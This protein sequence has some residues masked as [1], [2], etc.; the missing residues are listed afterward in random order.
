MNQKDGYD[1]LNPLRGGC[2]NSSIY[3]TILQELFHSISASI[4]F[5]SAILRKFSLSTYI[6]FIFILS[7]LKFDMECVF[8]ITSYYFYFI[9]WVN[10]LIVVWFDPASDADLLLIQGS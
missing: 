9:L 7:R 8:E 1:N 6:F 5:D 4:Y 10:S 3:K 2:C